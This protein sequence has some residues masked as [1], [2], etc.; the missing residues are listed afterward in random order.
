MERKRAD[1]SWSGC[2]TEHRLSDT[3]LL[4]Q[5]NSAFGRKNE[6][7]VV[8]KWVWRTLSSFK[9]EGAELKLRGIFGIGFCFEM[10]ILFS[11]KSACCSCLNNTKVF[12]S[13]SQ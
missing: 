8:M 1:R 5:S 11:E 3:R 9:V 10:I 7:V 4:C 6:V 12:W 13:I 2:C